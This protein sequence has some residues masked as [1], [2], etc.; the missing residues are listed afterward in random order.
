MRMIKTTYIALPY[1]IVRGL[2]EFMSLK[3]LAKEPSTEKCNVRGSQ[4]CYQALSQ[5]KSYA[6]WK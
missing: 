6:D 4:Y 2:N 3:S 1:G 5:P